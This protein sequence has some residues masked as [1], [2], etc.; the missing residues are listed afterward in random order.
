MDAILLP[1]RLRILLPISDT[2]A[3]ERFQQ[4]VGYEANK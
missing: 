4:E 2:T 1:A 3:Y